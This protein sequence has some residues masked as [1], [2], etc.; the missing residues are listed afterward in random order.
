MSRTVPPFAAEDA[1]R[2]TTR[3]QSMWR[4]RRSTLLVLS[5]GLASAALMGLDGWWAWSERAARLDAARQSAGR[6]A[7][8]AAQQADGVFDVANDI[9]LG[10]VERLQLDGAGPA[11]SRGLGDALAARIAAFPRLYEVV[12]ADANAVRLA[13]SRGD[14]PA[15][16]DSQLD[17]VIASQR[18]H[19]TAGAYAGLLQQSQRDG[20]PVVALSR[21]FD[22]ADGSFGGVVEVVVDLSDFRTLYRR[23]DPGPHGAISLWRDDGTL[24]VRQ[25]AAAAQDSDPVQQA[26]FQARRGVWEAPA[27]RLG[28]P[29]IYAYQ[30]LER[31]PL[32]VLY[33]VSTRDALDAWRAQTLGQAAVLVLLLGM[34]GVACWRAIRQIEQVRTAEGAHRVAAVT[35]QAEQAFFQA[36]FEYTTDCLFVQSVQPDGSFAAERIN[37]AAAQSVGLAAAADAVGRSPAALFGAEYGAILEA[38]LC[39]AQAARRP[40]SIADRVADGVTWE[41]IGVPIPGLGGDIE[42]ILLSAR[43]V[44]EQRRMQDAELLLRV[45]EEQRRLAAEATSER[46]DRLARHLARARDQAESA[47]QAKSRFLTNMSHELRTPLNAILGYAQLLRMEGGLSGGQTGHVEAML[48]AGRHLLEMITSVLDIAQIE[49]DKITLQSA[50]VSIPGV[51]QACLN[52]MRPVADSKQLALGF[53]AAP[54]AP[55]QLQVDPTRLRQVLLNLLGNAVKFTSAGSVTVR[56]SRVGDP[57]MMRLDIADT[58][59]GIPPVQ[60]ERLFEAFERMDNAGAAATEGAGLGLMISAR[61]VGAMGGRIGYESG[62][63]GAG[64]VF[65]FELPALRVDGAEIAPA[66]SSQDTA[67]GLRLLVVDDMANNRDI[68][69]AF[70]RS[71]GHR[72]TT[73]ASG[74]AAIRSAAAKNY[75]A[76]L[77]DVRMPGMDGLEATRQIRALPGSHGRVPIIAVTAQAFPEQIEACHQAGMDHHLSKPF[78]AAGLFQA[79]AVAMG[80]VDREE[81]SGSGAPA[82]GTPPVL[83]Q[84]MF[85]ATAAYLPADGL[86]THLQALAQ[87]GAALLDALRDGSPAVEAAALAHALAGAA[88]TFGF[89]LVADVG[90]RFE[91]AVEAGTAEQ[92]ALGRALVDATEATDALLAE[93]LAARM[94]AA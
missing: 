29:R 45:G 81:V 74:A 3:R 83:D 80:A 93:M 78:E 58:G 33:G 37:S 87:R 75:D 22:R 57:A 14:A 32:I 48:E 19:G 59:P 56:L 76:I 79:I 65:W 90:R 88:G 51:V 38:G 44:S 67:A 50:E 5:F 30:H 31:A 54:D 20:R 13:S 7:D 61:L 4:A 12:V 84:A 40:L 46:L 43:D 24:L 9:L 36:V 47:N 66:P 73:A 23:L 8:W 62:P 92:D 77:M 35:L 64:S 91:Y 68:A 60:R 63:G 6:S 53:T 72:V 27:D 94:V 71:A 52:L 1:S 39:Q 70:L 86:L 34:V 26:A 85:A 21:R 18:S 42:R 82:P 15:G 55:T 25:P 49:A 17:A 69:A 41:V 10:T 2:P 28:E 16:P 89:L 11:A